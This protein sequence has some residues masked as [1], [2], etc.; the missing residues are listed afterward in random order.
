AAFAGTAAFAGAAAFAIESAALAARPASLRARDR[1]AW[2]LSELL[3][4]IYTRSGIVIHAITKEG[5]DYIL[6]KDGRTGEDA[7]L[8]RRDSGGLYIGWLPPG[9]G[10]LP[11]ADAERPGE[12]IE[13]I[14]R[15]SV[16]AP[17]PPAEPPPARIAVVVDGKPLRTLGARD[18]AAVATVELR[19]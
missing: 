10:D 18:V 5:R 14:A 3:G 19:G 9:A 1:R 13:D 15:I 2:R 17:A 8:V 11:L 4:E 16:E 6:R 12:R 7:V